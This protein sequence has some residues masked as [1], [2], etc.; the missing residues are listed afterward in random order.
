MTDPAIV[1]LTPHWGSNGGIASHVVDSVSALRSQGVAVRVVAGEASAALPDFVALSPT[2]A[3]DRIDRAAALHAIADA[4]DVQTVIHVHDLQD[5]GF[6]GSLRGELPVVVSAHGYPGCSA[7]TYYFS[8]GHECARP[9]GPLCVAHMGLHG[10][11]HSKRV[12]RIPRLYRA[13][14]RRMKGYLSATRVVAYSSSVMRNLAA[15]RI[16]TARQAPMTTRRPSEASAP[17]PEEARVLFVGRV[18]GAKGLGVLVEAMRGHGVVLEVVGEG[19]D[20][21]RALERARQL[22]VDVDQRGWLTGADLE[23][24]YARAG[25]VVM[26]SLWPEPFGLVGIEAH[27]R[28]RAVVASDTGGIRDWLDDGESGLLVEPGNSTALHTA[29]GSLLADPGRAAKMGEVGRVRA[30]ERF[31]DERHVAGLMR[32]YSEALAA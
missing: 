5:N 23:A 10:C 14:S 24:A 1:V 22:D 19:W 25:F 20:L 31:N 13:T 29:I 18:V 7:N 2:L 9:Q 21:D 12:D 6:V 30:E 16:T 11:L 27:I 8:P 17:M 15:N 26:P 3:T 28:G 4:G 32:V